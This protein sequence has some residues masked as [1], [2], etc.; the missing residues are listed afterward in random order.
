MF[1]RL[2][3]AV[4]G[5]CRAWECS[6]STLPCSD[7]RRDRP[8]RCS[9]TWALSCCIVSCS[10]PNIPMIMVELQRLLPMEAAEA[11]RREAD[12]EASDLGAA[13]GEGRRRREGAGLLLSLLES[14][15]WL[16]KPSLLCAA[17]CRRLAGW[18]RA[19]SHP[20]AMAIIVSVMCCDDSTI[21]CMASNASGSCGLTLA[22]RAG[23][24]VSPES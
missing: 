8:A 12:V 13:G 24:T 22:A 3:A 18:R 6:V 10:W 14:E 1:G 2:W 11:G 9:L 21:I 5:F 16:D 23:T 15:V 7:S 19:S 17:C 4:T 20:W